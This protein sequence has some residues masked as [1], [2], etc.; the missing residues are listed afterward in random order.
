MA[1]ILVIAEHSLS[2]QVA[3]Y[4]ERQIGRA[5]L[6]RVYAG[7]VR[8]LVDE[9]R[10]NPEAY[11]FAVLPNMYTMGAE[12]ALS[13]YFDLREA[14]HDIEIVGCVP[15]IPSLFL[16]GIPGAT[17]DEI[18]VVRSHLEALSA[19]RLPL[20]QLGIFRAEYGVSHT[21]AAAKAVAEERRVEVA[22]LASERAGRAYGLVRLFDRPL[23]RQRTVP[24]F[25]LGREPVAF[26][27]AYNRTLVGLRNRPELVKRVLCLP[28]DLER[29]F[30]IETDDEE[31]WLLI[32]LRGDLQS[33]SIADEVKEIQSIAG[34]DY[35]FLGSYWLWDP[36]RL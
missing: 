26:A 10:S 33:G 6:E 12:Y 31:E 1:K 7:T 24:F 27:S 22:A 17:L 25:L 4:I 16:W 19:C 35:E 8:G 5:D 36:L 29:I 20:R 32:Q 3:D 11:D 28:L 18:R 14:R 30:T 34:P 9:F 2:D 23:N 21:A 15:V 13:L